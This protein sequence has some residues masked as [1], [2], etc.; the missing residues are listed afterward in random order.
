MGCTGSAAITGFRHKGLERFFAVGAS[1]EFKLNT[2]T[3]SD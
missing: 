2:L 3:G 1:Q